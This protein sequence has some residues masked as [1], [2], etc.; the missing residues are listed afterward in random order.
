MLL[1]LLAL[2]AFLMLICASLS[3]SMTR[4]RRIW[5]C[6]SS[7]SHLV[8]SIASYIGIRIDGCWGENELLK[9]GCTIAKWVY[10]RTCGC[11]RKVV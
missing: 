8:T 11:L 7:M 3:S 10:E 4:N 1:A 6:R 5:A 2:L 9:C